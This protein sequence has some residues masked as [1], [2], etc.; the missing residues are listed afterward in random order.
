MIKIFKNAISNITI[1]DIAKIYEKCK[2][3]NCSFEKF[4]SELNQY[5]EVLPITTRYYY[6]LF[7]YKNANF[8]EA[9]KIITDTLNILENMPENSFEV[10]FSDVWKSVYGLA[11]EIFSITNQNNEALNAFQNY[12]LCVCRIKSTSIKKGLITF[13]NYNEHSLSDIINN[14]ITV[15]S[16]CV[17]NDPYDTLILKWGEYLKE[18]KPDKKHIEQYCKS[19]NSYRIRSFT[20]A[21]DLR[22]NDMVSNVLM[23]SH[24]AGQHTGYCIEYHFSDKFITVTEPRRT[25]RLK[26]IIY[27][28]IDTPLDISANTIDT[29]LGLC[30]KHSDWCYEN[31]VRL[32]TYEPDIEG[33]FN[34]IPLDKDSYIKRIYFGYKCSKKQIET[35]QRMLIGHRNIEYYKMQSDYSNILHLFPKE[36]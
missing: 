1:D 10:S 14:E 16:P 25:I 4:K 36:L 8:I 22:G 26:D 21:Q 3:T 28:N 15:C 20:R 11:G 18:S 19:L 7:S 5:E 13:R 34:S 9:S 23:W 32:I 30:T 35:I 24:Y 12:Q 2:N 6:A 29:N 31:E 33:P 17:M 27:H